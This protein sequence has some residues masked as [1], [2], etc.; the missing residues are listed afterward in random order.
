[1]STTIDS[2]V[3]EMRFDNRHFENN[4]STTMSTLDKLKQKLHLDGAT[5]GLENV[6]SAAKKVDM[7]G[8]ATGVETI[9]SKFSAMEVMGVTALANITNSAVNAGKRIISAL[10]IDPV[11]TGF[12]EYETQINSTQTILANTK[13]KGSTIEDVNK[14]LEELNRYA[15]MTIYNFTEMTRNIGTFTAAGIDLDTSVN[16]IQGIANLA[17]VSGSTS[18]QAST[19]MYQLSQ[20]LAAGTIRLMDWNSVVNAG[21]GGEVF[22]NALKKTSEELGTGAEAAIK[23]SGSFRESLRDGW[24]TAEV[25]TETLKKFTSSGANEYV[26]EYTGLSKEAVETAIKEGEAVAEA[27]K[28]RG[29]EVD[30]I[31]AAAEA[32]AKKSGKNKQEIYD[33]LD[34]AR[35]ATDAATKVKTFTQLWDVLK[36]SA[37]S[38]WAQTW[39]IIVGDFEEAK[40]L[41]TPLADVLTGIINKTSEWR[42]AILESALGKSFASLGEKLNGVIEPATAAMDTVKETAKAVANLDEIVTKVIRGEFGNG[43]DRFNK[44]T[45][46]G[47]N[48]YKVQNKVNE[49]L[50]NGFRYTEEEIAA[51][52]KLLG[53]KTEVTEK[54]EEQTEATVK[55]ND[56][57]KKRL[58]T[59]VRMSEAELKAAGYTKP[60]IEALKELAKQA[61][62]LGIP[63]DDFID[64]MD[65]ITGR[66][67][68]IESFKN[69]GKGLADIF[70]VLKIAWESIFPP[71]SIEEIAT[72]IFNIIG[73][74]HKLTS[75]FRLYDEET[76]TWTET[77]VNLCKTLKGVFAIFSVITT[78]LNGGV[79]IA[80]KVITQILSYFNL[81]ILEVTAAIGDAAVKFKEWFDSI[82]DVTGILDVLVP[83]VKNAAEAIGKWFDAFKESKGLQ[84]TIKYIKELVADIKNWWASLT[85]VEDLP[86]TLAEGI[87]NF[88][89]NIP[90]I[91]RTVLSNIRSAVSEA[92]GGINDNPLGGLINKLRKGLSIA[93][94]TVVEIGKILLANLNKF[95]SAHGFAEISEDAIAGL[96]NGL[97][98]G[99]TKAWNAA[100]EMAKGIVEKVK[101][102]LGIHSPSTVFA[103]IGGFIIAGL[104]A[105]L[106]N[107]IPDSLGAIKDVFQPMLDWIKG[108]DFGALLAGV[109]GIGTVKA[110]GTAAGALADFAAPF[111]GLGEVLENSADFIKKMT[112]P[113]KNVVNGFAKIEKAAAFNMR[114]DGIKTLAISLLM[115]VGAVAVLTF[116]EPAELWNA[117]G[118]I[119]VLAAIMT[120]LAFAMSKINNASASFD[121]KNGLN[122]QGLTT[123]LIG[124]GAA[125]LLLGITVKMVG[126]LDPEQAKQGFLGLAGLVVA[127]GVVVAAFGLLVKGD[128]ANN[129]GKFGGMM[130]KLSIALMLMVGVVKLAAKLTNDDLIAG[131]KFLGGFLA[132][133]LAINLIALIPSKN[134]DKLGGMMLKM[135]ISLLL[136]V[137]VIKLIALLNPHEMIA[138]A[139]FLIVFVAFIGIL[140][141]IG[142][143]GGKAIDGVGKMML[144]LSVSLLLMVGVVKLIGLLTPRELLQGGI[145]IAAFTAI[146]ALLVK[147]VVSHGDKA[148]KVAATILAYSIAIGILAAIAIVCGLIDIQGLAKGVIAVGVLSAMMALLIHSTKDATNVTGTIVSI[149]IAIGLL[150]AAVAVLTLIDPSKLA[151]AT[152][153]MTIL[154][155][156]LALVVKMAGAAQNA[157]GVVATIA[158]CIIAIGGVLYLLST[159]P[160]EST[161]GSAIALGGL[162]LVLAGILVVLAKL[163]AAAETAKSGILALALLGAVV[164]E[165]AVIL[166]LMS[167]LKVEPSLASAAAIS[168][169]LITMTG[170]L[171]ILT[172]IGPAATLAYPAM[173]ALGVLIAGLVA[174]LAALGG[175]SK[176]PGFN[177]LIADGGGVLASIGHALGTFVGSIVSGFAGEV[178][179]ILPAFGQ[180]LSG[181]MGGAQK[182][183]DGASNIDISLLTGVGILSAAILA[184]TA[185]DLIAGLATLGGL[186]LVALGAS[187]S[188]F[189]IAAKPFITNAAMITPEMMAGVKALAETI[190]ILTAADLLDGINLFGSS[191]LEKFASQL[192]ILG[193]GLVGFASSLGTFSEEQLT[194]V[195][196]AA[197]AVKTLAQASSEIP[198]TG[199]LLAAIVGENDLAT[200]ASQFPILGTGLAQ[201]LSNIGTFTEEQVATVNC[202]AQAIKSLAQASSEIPNAGGWLGQIVGENDLGTFAT[203]FPILGTGLAQF[204]T[205]VGTFTDEQVAT[206]DCAA[207]AIKTLAKASSEIPN[208][209]GWLGQ[210]VGENDLATFADQFPIL[211]TGLAGFLTNIGTFT[212][213]QVATVN[214]AANAIKSLAQVSSEIPNSGGLL[215]AIVGDNDLG[216]FATQLPSLGQGIKNFVGKLGTFTSEQVTTVNA[217]VS[218]IRALAELAGVNLSGLTKH[219]GDLGDDLPDFAEDLADFCSKM[220]ASVDVSTA[221]ANIRR[222]ISVIKDVANANS[223]ALATFAKDLKKIGK[224]AVE[225]FV[226]A[227]TSDATKTDVKKAAKDL[228]DAIVK[229]IEAKEDDIAD[230]AKTVADG[231]VSAVE[232]QIIDMEGAG[233]DLG[234]GLVSGIKSKV[235][236]AYVAGYKLGQA[237]VEGEKDGQKSNSP[238][239]LTIQAGKWIGEGL[240]IGMG[241]MGGKVYAAGNTL[242]KTATSTISSTISNI[243]AAVNTDIDSQPTIRPVLDL[244]DVRSGARSIS[245]MFGNGASVGVMANVNSISSM[246]SSRGQNGA[247]ADVVSA[248]DR[249]NKKMDSIGNT[250]YQINGVTYDDGSN[251]AEAVK[252]ITRAA[253]RERRV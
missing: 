252:S 240:I 128:S 229:G 106:Q 203:Q 91:I 250:S 201:F 159:L 51:Q 4:V 47:I 164:A 39:K 31:D 155:G 191:P 54:T 32:L 85:D 171:A 49:S 213:E 190:L 179:T 8:I 114:M 178:L 151:V 34:F 22:Q 145:A 189:M 158:G 169:L 126:S 29:E 121:F 180:A 208:S 235:G 134:I 211:G 118:I 239:K 35:N 219:L 132:F 37:Q 20:A 103:A 83:I 102:F 154:M 44:L 243:A 194:T 168:L 68:L 166:G 221:V 69:I 17:A 99:A 27:A 110:A 187:L 133:L 100:L 109:I 18:Q 62:K 70:K 177:D 136:M 138:G 234:S 16:A 181:F 98:D 245:S 157:W 25:L 224:D 123:G 43:E 46:A 172:K 192:P 148:P 82:F 116:F 130:L 23:A 149:A 52:D 198:N 65:Q 204:L 55:L 207:Q 195:N 228:G 30:A 81:N 163:G 226:E 80:F 174:V 101:D 84:D 19:A 63:L 141:A 75:N 153:A 214:C 76:E 184:L 1:M 56:E 120:A 14:A 96:V 122:V 33:M 104:V 140:S 57:Q 40:G 48:Y 152:T 41:L 72:G 61:E 125:I 160:V 209:G 223:G 2:K 66:W 206:V 74:F 119:A 142:G 112:K 131:A 87:V 200:F 231:A 94:Q 150:V 53:T 205:N 60:Q 3:V 88:F 13:S 183:I 64:K 143:L 50:N 9:G 111:A 244:S 7:S 202:A 251:I 241:K 197:R 6:G 248:I 230:A 36:E 77:G 113:I 12:Q 182:F 107:G 186:G 173:L 97:K 26:A 127:I 253:V 238:S 233:K 249:L 220:P 42:N 199:G 117:V 137:G 215:A 92:F 217:G 162:M 193:K 5:K 247:N 222:I 38:G 225:K 89:S 11:K 90:T 129:I 95:L 45:E 185:A 144:S 108:I 21:M 246:M 105:G 242:G 161:I 175:L 93:G 227:F 167:Y 216:T 71:K 165:I 58:K 196:C 139:Q 10:T 237:A 212:D 218:A 79:R 156:M 73:A 170:V 59:L 232:T 67:L 86:K 210:I 236:E 135:S 15:D 28:A 78:I 24:L 146:I 147:S 176:I 188:G 124:I 115:L